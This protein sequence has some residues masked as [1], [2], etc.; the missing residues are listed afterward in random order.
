MP[1]SG[2]ASSYETF[3]QLQY[4]EGPSESPTIPSNKEQFLSRRNLHEQQKIPNK[5]SLDD[6][7]SCGGKHNFVPHFNGSVCFTVNM[8]SL[9]FVVLKMMPGILQQMFG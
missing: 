7:C 8:Y 9:H 4:Q 5:S 2:N 6:S 1:P 3:A